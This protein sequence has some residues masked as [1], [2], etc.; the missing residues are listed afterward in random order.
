MALSPSNGLSR[1]LECDRQTDR[2]RYGKYAAIGGI[3]C[4]ARGDSA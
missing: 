4:A 1:G 3:A 2:P